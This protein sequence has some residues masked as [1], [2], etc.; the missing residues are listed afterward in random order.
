MV[1][2]AGRCTRARICI[3]YS[4]INMRSPRGSL[5]AM[6]VN[7][8]NLHLAI[9]IAIYARMRSACK[10]RVQTQFCGFFWTTGCFIVI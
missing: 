9:L 8:K 3:V 5:A 4:P 2:A 7:G 6:K 10:P 1:Y